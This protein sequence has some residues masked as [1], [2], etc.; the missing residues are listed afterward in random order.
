MRYFNETEEIKRRF[1]ENGGFLIDY[2]C[3]V[4][5]FKQ[6]MM[7]CEVQGN[8]DYNIELLLA[9]AAYYQEYVSRLLEY[10]K[11]CQYFVKQDIRCLLDAFKHRLFHFKYEIGQLNLKG[12]D[13]L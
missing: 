4:V 5:S 3:G 9:I 2:A 10:I 13:N 6:Y 7:K 1:G 11:S 12:I 8:D